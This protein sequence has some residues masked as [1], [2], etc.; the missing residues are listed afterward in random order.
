MRTT[1]DIKP[2]KLYLI[3]FVAAFC[4]GSLVRHLVAVREKNNELAKQAEDRKRVQ[5]MFKE[6]REHLKKFIEDQK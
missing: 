5:Q 3:I 1:I 6:D 4:T 2:R